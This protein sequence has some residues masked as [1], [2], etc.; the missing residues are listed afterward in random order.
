[1]LLLIDLFIFSSSGWR[2]WEL[3]VWCSVHRLV[4]VQCQLFPLNDLI[5]LKNHQ[6]N[7]NQIW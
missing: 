5:L 2:L 7:F 4:S 6:D 3:M 1:M